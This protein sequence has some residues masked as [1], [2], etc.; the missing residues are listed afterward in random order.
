MDGGDRRPVDGPRLPDVFLAEGVPGRQPAGVLDAVAV[1][2][3]HYGVHGVQHQH[4]G[5]RGQRDLTDVCQGVG[6]ELVLSAPC[7]PVHLALDADPQPL[8]LA[9]T[10][11]LV[12]LIGASSIVG[13]RFFGVV[14]QTHPAIL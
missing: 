5:V 14:Q 1:V 4:V 12:L 10:A 9:E 8:G 7:Q 2:E 13:Q 6:G 3:V 11:R